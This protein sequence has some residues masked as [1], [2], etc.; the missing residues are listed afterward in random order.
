M[1]WRSKKKPKQLRRYARMHPNGS[2]GTCSLGEIELSNV[3]PMGLGFSTSN[4]AGFAPGDRH[5]VIVEDRKGRS[6]EAFGEI[7]WCGEQPR[8]DGSYSVGLAFVSILRDDPLGNWTG[9]AADPA[10]EAGTASSWQL[11]AEGSGSEAEE[12][13]AASAKEE[14]PRVLSL[15]SFRRRASR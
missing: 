14:R 5:L 8:P 7:R 3:S 6:F 9:I 12:P 2:R 10:L 13:A 11:P 15:A 1:M 4:Q